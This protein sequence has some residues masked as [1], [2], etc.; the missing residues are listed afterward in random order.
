MNEQPTTVSLTE[1]LANAW[2]RED[3]GES[4]WT[5]AIFFFLCFFFVERDDWPITSGLG[6]AHCVPY[7]EKVW[8]E[9]SLNMKGGCYVKSHRH[10]L[11]LSAANML[12]ALYVVANMLHKMPEVTTDKRI[13][14]K[15]MQSV[16]REGTPTAG[17]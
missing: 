9:T 1:A 11:F 14:M 13:V 15:V 2:L 12:K 8:T 6:Q 5:A 10:D 7:T 4:N 17:L 3:Q 16:L